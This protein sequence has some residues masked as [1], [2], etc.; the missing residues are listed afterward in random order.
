MTRKRKKDIISPSNDKTQ[1][2]RKMASNSSQ[3]TAA[4]STQANVGQ[5]F[6][7]PP[8]YH[9]SSPY[10][11]GQTS[12]VAFQ[13]TVSNVPTQSG[14]SNEMLQG[15]IQRLDSMDSKLNQLNKI[16]LTVDKI[17]ERLNTLDKKINDIERSNVFL[18]EQYEEL[19]SSTIQ[20]SDEISKL[21]NDMKHINDENLK[22]KQKNAEFS[23][24]ITDLKCRS[25]RDNLLFFGIPE[26][27]A[28][29]PT[30]AVIQSNTSDLNDVYGS[31]QDII[32]PSQPP[33]MEPMSTTKSTQHVIITTTDE[34]CVDK[35]KSFCENILGIKDAKSKIVIQ[36]AHRVGRSIPGKIR[37]IV[38][39]LESESKS[40]IKNALKVIN[41]K[42]TPCNV[43][44]QYPPEVKDRRK[45][46][47]PI[48]VEARRL[49]KKAVLVRVFYVKYLCWV[50][51]QLYCSIVMAMNTM[52]LC[53]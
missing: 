47:I 52:C 44:D 21:K 48:M 20:H 45:E 11:V 18:S 42:N 37:P 51:R 8:M 31:S 19:S 32:D 33:N 41:L 17:T 24:S 28:F 5:S 25:M 9:P 3:N 40:I 23:D 30:P 50:Y 43:A 22:L 13:S 4:S 10:Y 6:I 7:L 27:E 26:N 39:K 38:A 53:Y 12:L 34:N 49:G 16:Q 1:T 36:R 15:I 46:L 14:L 2:K 35:C 29:N